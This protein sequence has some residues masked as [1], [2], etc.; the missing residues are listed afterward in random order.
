MK[1]IILFF[2]S[3]ICFADNVHYP[4]PRSYKLVNSQY[5]CCASYHYFGFDIVYLPCYFYHGC[6]ITGERT[7]CQACKNGTCKTYCPPTCPKKEALAKHTKAIKFFEGIYGQHRYFN[8]LNRKEKIKII[9]L[10]EKRKKW[11]EN[12]EKEK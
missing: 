2:I 7:G 10:R 4:F 8:E 5:G 9:Q 3:S 1:I 6:K 11:I 12:K